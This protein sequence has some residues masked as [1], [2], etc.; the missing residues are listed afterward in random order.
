MCS[1]MSDS[2]RPRGLQP[3]R[4]LCSQHFQARMLEWVAISS[5]RG[6]SQPRDQT[7][8][9]C[10]SCVSCIGRWILYHLSYLHVL[11]IQRKV[12]RGFKISE[13]LFNSNERTLYMQF[14]FFI[15]D[16]AFW[17]VFQVTKSLLLYVIFVKFFYKFLKFNYFFRFYNFHFLIYRKSISGLIFHL[18]VSLC[19]LFLCSLNILIS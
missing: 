8:V 13:I 7:R 12:L 15:L 11:D 1:V 3:T 10:V 19:C 4:L 17:L 2:L 14:F 18:F 16:D 6:S 9:S 5:S